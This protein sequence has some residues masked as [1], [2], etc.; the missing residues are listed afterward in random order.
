[1]DLKKI[2]A[3][4]DQNNAVERELSQ[5]ILRSHFGRFA[6]WQTFDARRE[7]GQI[8][9]LAKWR[10]SQQ[11]AV[12]TWRTN[13]IAVSWKDFPNERLAKKFYLKVNSENPFSV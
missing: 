2:V 3:E 9:A 6:T 13:E 12:V 11:V 10:K 5:V 8:V 4:M 1:M 7:N